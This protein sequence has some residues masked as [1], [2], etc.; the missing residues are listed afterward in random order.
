[1]RSPQFKNPLKSLNIIGPYKGHTGYDHH[2]REFTREL[3]RQGVAVQLRD[4]TKWSTTKLA[5]DQQD[6]W[7]D[8]LRR[9]VN[10]GVQLHFVMPPQVDIASNKR[11]VNFTMFEA[12]RIPADWL[13]HNFRHDLVILP[14]ESSRQAWLNSGYPKERIRLCR[15]GVNVALFQRNVEPLPLEDERGRPVMDYGTRVLNISELTPRK[16][17]VGLLRTW[18]QSTSKSD[19]AILIIKANC[20]WRRWLFK[21]FFDVKLMEKKIG[22]S[23]KDAAPVLF[24]INRRFSDA[25]MPRL[26]ATASHYWSMSFGEG[27]DLCMM[28][29]GAVGLDLIA[30][31]HS[32]YSTYLNPRIADMIPSRVVPAK[33]RWAHGLHKCFAGANWW[34]PDERAAANHICQAINNGG[35]MRNGAARAHIAEHFTWQ[36]A[37]AQLIEILSALNHA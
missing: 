5:E 36:K 19:D 15:L 22:K 1:M 12:D 28:E 33:F 14:T 30:P 9:P 16:N 13:K 37:T 26:Y 32:A 20:L 31:A 4:L 3:V 27:W 23:R 35:K 34:Q 29:A 2:V 8:T 17:L 11:N 24:L 6:D 10:A 18:I 25:E 21:F 7:F